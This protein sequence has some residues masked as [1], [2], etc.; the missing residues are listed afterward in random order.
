[1]TTESAMTPILVFFISSYFV[2]FLFEE[3]G[4]TQLIC[5]VEPSLIMNYL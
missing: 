3:E 2:Y 4:S 1:M 5:R